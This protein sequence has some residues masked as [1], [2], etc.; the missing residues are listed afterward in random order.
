MTYFSLC[1]PIC[2]R[3]KV[4]ENPS[5]YVARLQCGPHEING[6]MTMIVV[7]PPSFLQERRKYECTRSPDEK[8]RDSMAKYA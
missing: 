2:G 5:C 8:E 7:P 4:F 6:R 1:C 3:T